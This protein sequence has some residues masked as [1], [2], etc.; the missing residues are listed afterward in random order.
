MELVSYFSDKD[1][2]I[3][4]INDNFFN[5][6]CYPYSNEKS[7]L[8]LSDRRNDIFQNYSLC[9]SGCD[10]KNIDTNSNEL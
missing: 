10:Y 7:D 1:V 3:F 2:N 5:N 8:V 6:I 4:D 9:E